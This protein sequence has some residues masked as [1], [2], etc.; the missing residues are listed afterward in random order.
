LENALG[1]GRLLAQ[2]LAL[3]SHSLTHSLSISRQKLLIK[4]C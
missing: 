3:D 2:A 4:L 1:L